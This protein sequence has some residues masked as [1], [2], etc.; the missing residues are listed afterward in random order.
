MPSIGMDYPD[1]ILAQCDLVVASIHAAMG[2]TRTGKLSPT[3][4]TI[5]AMENPY[6]TMIGH[7]TGRLIHRRAPMEMD[8]PAIVEAAARTDTILEVNASWQRL[9]LKDVHIRMALAAGA[10]IAIN[11]D[12]HNTDQ[13]EFMR[14]GVT[15]ARRGGATPKD[16][17]NCMTLANLRKRLNKKRAVYKA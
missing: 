5:G 1:E 2:S 17:L 13:F 15:T 12:A 6:V 10:M 16:I 9:D 4:R 3:H 8:M 11:T 14:Y 7:P